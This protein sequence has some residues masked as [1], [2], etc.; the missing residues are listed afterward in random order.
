MFLMTAHG[1]L[2]CSS[3]DDDTITHCHPFA[4]RENTAP[5]DFKQISLEMAEQFRAFVEVPP[6]DQN[7]VITNVIL[8]GLSF[9]RS[10]DYKTVKLMRDGFYMTALPNGS[11]GFHTKDQNTWE[12]YMALST[13]DLEALKTILSA[14]WIEQKTNNLIEPHDIRI[15]EGWKLRLGEAV[16]DLRLQFPTISSDLPFHFVGLHDGWRIV[17]FFLYDPLIYFTAFKSSEVLSQLYI[18]ICSLLEFGCYDGKVHVVTDQAA[19]TIL[20]NIPKLDP[21]RLSIQ[22]CNPADWVG[23]VAAKYTIAEHQPAYGHQPILFSDPDIVFDTNI[24]PMLKTIASSD[25]IVAPLEG[26]LLRTFPSLGATLYQRDGFDAGFASG[27]NGGTL[28]IPNLA[29]HGKTLD[30]IRAIIVNHALLHGRDYHRWVDQ[31]TANY[32]SFRI[33]NVDTHAISS[34]V[35]TGF[36]DTAKTSNGR[37]GLVHFWASTPKSATMQAY[38]EVLRSA[39]SN[40]Q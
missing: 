15:E 37:R 25:R 22:T 31:E 5:I 26:G 4:I 24:L 18:S 27:F 34:Y 11:V 35:R 14:R 40:Y 21:S 29:S 39:E 28:G 16:L 3:R 8:P 17:R 19:D 38:V 12:L 23:Y 13:K 36:A 9:A 30:L 2:L 1:T 32:V 10:K 7:T 20:A 6:E 33:A